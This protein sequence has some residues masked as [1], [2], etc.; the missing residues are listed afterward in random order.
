MTD[1]KHVHFRRPALG[2]AVY[3]TVLGTK[4][5]NYG[6]RC[7][8]C[9]YA[10]TS[11]Q[12]ICEIYPRGYMN[13]TVICGVCIQALADQIPPDVTDARME[14]IAGG[15]PLV[16]WVRSEVVPSIAAASGLVLSLWWGQGVLG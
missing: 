10:A 4:D 14:K 13:P 16:G 15:S 1:P 5:H 6:K 12:V 9:D 7:S 2:K 3:F 11:G 8:I